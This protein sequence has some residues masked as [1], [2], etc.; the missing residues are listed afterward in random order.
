MGTDAQTSYSVNKVGYEFFTIKL[1]HGTNSKPAHGIK[2][3]CGSMVGKK[4]K[5]NRMILPLRSLL[6][7][8]K[9]QAKLALEK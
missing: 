6:Q 3:Y 9:Q 7:H 1:L 8:T 2:G 5:K 4:K